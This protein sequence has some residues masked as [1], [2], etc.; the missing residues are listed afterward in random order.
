MLQQVKY[1]SKFMYKIVFNGN[2]VLARLHTFGNGVLARLCT[3]GNDTE[4]L[5]KIR[6]K[7]VV[8]YYSYSLAYNLGFSS[9][10]DVVCQFT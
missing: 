8:T 9:L 5:C 6:I 1:T 2:D 3:F 4:A 10:Y 7:K